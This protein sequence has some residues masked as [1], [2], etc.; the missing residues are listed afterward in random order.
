[1]SDP[2][3]DRIL[4]ELTEL[5]EGYTRLSNL[6]YEDHY[7]MEQA[8][9]EADDE[10]LAP[11]DVV[12]PAPAGRTP[13]PQLASSLQDRLRADAGMPY[14]EASS[15]ALAS[16]NLLADPLME[17][18]LSSGT[19]TVG[20]TWTSVGD[21]WEAR[22]VAIA[23][24]A[25]TVTAQRTF[26]RTLM[27]GQLY[28]SNIIVLDIAYAALGS[29]YVE[30]RPVAPVAAPIHVDWPWVVAA[31]RCY[32]DKVIRAA[33]NLEDATDDEYAEDDETDT[34]ESTNFVRAVMSDGASWLDPASVIGD[35][36]DLQK[37]SDELAE[38][39][40]YVASDTTDAQHW[41]GVQIYTSVTAAGGVAVAVGE[42]QVNYCYQESPMPFTPA[43]DTWDR[44]AD[45]IVPG[46]PGDDTKPATITTLAMTAAYQQQADGS[47]I[48][49]LVATW[50]LLTSLDIIGYELQWKETGDDWLTAE[51]LKVGI[52]TDN[53]DGTTKAVTLAKGVLGGVSYDV[54]I[55]GYDMEA[56][57]G[58]WS[59][60]ETVTALAD[61]SAPPTPEPTAIS[62]YKLIA[63]QWD[64]SSAPDLAFYQVRYTTTPLDDESW[65]IVQ[66][67]SSRVVITGLDYTAEY[68]LQVRAVD[69]SGNVRVSLDPATLVEVI[70]SYEDETIGWSAAVLATPGKVGTQD[71]AA[72]SAI[73]GF[74]D[75]GE[76]DAD[77]INAGSLT[78]GGNTNDEYAD[79]I[80][81]YDAAL[82][83]AQLVGQWT[84]AGILLLDPDESPPNQ[85][86]MLLTEGE[87]KFS[88]S[89]TGDV[90]TTIWTT[91]VGPDGISA[92]AILL[93]SFSGGSNRMLNAGIE[94]AVFAITV[95]TSATWT[96]S[97]E[98]ATA[99]EMVNMTTT[100]DQL[101]MSTV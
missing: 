67:L 2:W 59:D 45:D 76:I 48:P 69:R 54:R 32:V 63:L 52:S 78:V 68:T 79:G 5:R 3:R 44:T 91:A 47:S 34:T 96:T 12:P 41:A 26:D 95:R 77:W 81:V 36:S 99:T 33:T 71:I 86:A 98:L 27:E 89:Y 100:G 24:A 25:A 93:G 49:V 8:S 51:V 35:E 43:L 17:E 29:S 84:S 23:G 42:P 21:G 60:T 101:T 58:D 72:T 61:S 94:L 65:T 64:Q 38:A 40:V 62:G 83:T 90:G 1:M 22:V 39:Q 66:T 92:D 16:A 85:S 74:L 6:S 50:T 31:F 13:V 37:M 10:H 75:S 55:R 73:I 56:M 87:L 80:S 70:G 15:A 18:I 53:V 9:S 30:L 28:R 4:S 57:L 14:F 82:P 11:G 7:R 20:T 19:V 97:A 88:A 46:Y